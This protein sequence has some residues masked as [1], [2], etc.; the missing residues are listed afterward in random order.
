MPKLTKPT[1]QQ[2]SAHLAYEIRTFNASRE[3]AKFDLMRQIDPS[4]FVLTLT[5][6]NAQQPTKANNQP[7]LFEVSR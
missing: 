6:P 2:L 5:P 4:A 1:Q 3:Q 7:S